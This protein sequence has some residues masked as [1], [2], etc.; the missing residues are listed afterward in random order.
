M[1]KQIIHLLL[2]AIS[3]C[4]LNACKTQQNSSK[5]NDPITSAFL[6]SKK[7]AGSFYSHNIY[8]SHYK[9]QSGLRLKAAK[10]DSLAKPLVLALHWAGS[11]DAYERFSSCLIEPTF[12][13]KDV[14]IIVPDAMGSVWT[15]EYHTESILQLIKTAIQVWNVDEERILVCGYS[16]GGNGSYYFI[17]NYPEIFKAAIPMAAHYRSSKKIDAPIYAIHGDQDE[18]FLLQDIEKFATEAQNLGTNLTLKVLEGFSH[19]DACSMQEAFSK[20]L[21]WI[22]DNI[23]GGF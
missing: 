17:E 3:L 9:I 6:F 12:E 10:D 23:N 7:F 13:S 16:N 22:N 8:N 4:A 21:T 14:H 15:T 19:Y 20:G 5:L 1:P 18:L 11:G 2:M